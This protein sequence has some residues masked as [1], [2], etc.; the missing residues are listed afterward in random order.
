L[1]VAH[2]FAERDSYSSALEGKSAL[3]RL[4]D[5]WYAHFVLQAD[6]D[7]DLSLRRALRSAGHGEM[8]LDVP[9]RR[10]VYS[11]VNKG[12]L[13]SRRLPQEV[14]HAGQVELPR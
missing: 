9:N 7:E 12:S 2:S 3:H 13:D 1:G 11:A 14:E 5:E 6:S 4:F 10:L 8:R